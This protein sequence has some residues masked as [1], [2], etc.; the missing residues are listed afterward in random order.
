MKKVISAATAIGALA[1]FA[2]PA[3][4]A[5]PTTYLIGHGDSF[6]AKVSFKVVDGEVRS[7]FLVIPNMPVKRAGG[8]TVHTYAIAAIAHA[9]RA[10]GS[11]FKKVKRTRSH[12][13]GGTR[14]RFVFTG[15]L[16][17]GTRPATGH[18]S[19][20]VESDYLWFNTH[21]V[22]WSAEPVSQ[23]RFKTFRGIAPAVIHHHRA[24]GVV[25]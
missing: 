5:T 18:T 16:W 2:S 25:G 13:L 14:S 1:L 8:G 4:G 21:K 19:F 23:A 9:P 7:A 20:R 17:D 3:L 15:H 24:F 10:K 6:H 22:D 11:G 12:S